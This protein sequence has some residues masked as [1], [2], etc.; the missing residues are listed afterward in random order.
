[1]GSFAYS[2]S[3][4]THIVAGAGGIEMVMLVRS[5]RELFTDFID[6]EAKAQGLHAV[7]NGS[8]ID[9]SFAAKVSATVRS[10]P[11]DP[12]D[13]APVG[14]VI[15]SGKM[16]AGASS[17]GKFHFSQNT[18]GKNS[19]TAGL[20][21]PPTTSCSAIGGIAPIVVA[22]MA[23]GAENKYKAGVPAGAPFTGDVDAKFLPFLFQKSN[24]MYAG[25]L[26][27]G[28]LVGKTAVGFSDSA[29]SLLVLSQE[30]GAS[31][32]DANG[33]RTLMLGAKMTNAVFLDCSDSA[34]LH[35]G[36]KFLVKPGPAKDR[37]LTIAVGFR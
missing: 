19:F 17:S 37:F 3:G 16:L 8:F 11:L 36:G 13:S 30:D 35:Y 1:M 22:G 12:A 20:G 31:G 14:Q 2:F 6:R 10:G 4:G 9:L 23:Y 27:R 32:F 33:I 7:V 24:A 15:Q 5:K 25:V 28:G 34:T 18:C 26:A 21:N 29:Q